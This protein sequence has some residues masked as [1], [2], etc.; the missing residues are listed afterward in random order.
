MVVSPVKKAAG[1]YCCAYACR[2]EPIEKKDGLCHKHYARKRREEDPIGVRFNQFKGNARK[3]GKAFSITIEEFRGFCEETGYL[4]K[5]R[6]G[7]NATIDRRDNDFGY[8]LWNIQI[9]TNR[10]NAS[11]GARSE[12]ECPF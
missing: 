8:H 2:N 4:T 7:Q 12:V 6:R 11:K 5:G 9:L 3:R 1:R 10:Q